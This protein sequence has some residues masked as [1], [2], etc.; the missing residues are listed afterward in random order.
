MPVHLFCPSVN[1]I[2]NILGNVVDFWLIEGADKFF[3]ET[4]YPIMPFEYTLLNI[5][6][7]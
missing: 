2:C 1:L 6:V 5:P 7:R 4:I 3:I